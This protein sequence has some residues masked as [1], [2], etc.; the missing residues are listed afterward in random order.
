MKTTTLEECEETT[1]IT[2]KKQEDHVPKPTESI[3]N[4]A[5]TNVQGN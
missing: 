5:S 3:G 4:K 2:D 1:P